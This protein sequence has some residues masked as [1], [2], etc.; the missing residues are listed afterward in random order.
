MNQR[1][2]H[3][4]IFILMFSVALLVTAC[5]EDSPTKPSDNY[6]VVAGTVFA[7]GKSVLPGVSVSIGNQ[8]TITN[9]DGKFI[10]SGVSPSSRVLVNFAISG[11]TSST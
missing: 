10:I 11:R 7:P 4:V 8:S 3:V 2:I 9:N 1:L 6:G 5:D